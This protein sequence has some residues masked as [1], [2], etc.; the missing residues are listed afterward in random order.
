MTFTSVNFYKIII[1]IKYI[2]FSDNSVQS[3]NYKED[4]NTVKYLV[5]YINTMCYDDKISDV[6]QNLYNIFTLF[7][8]KDINNESFIVYFDNLYGFEIMSQLQKTHLTFMD[9]KN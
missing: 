4:I 7:L 8:Q 6:T 5:K 1:F 3:Y 2:N 9:S